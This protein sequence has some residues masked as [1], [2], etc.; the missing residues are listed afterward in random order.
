LEGTANESEIRGNFFSVRN[1][2]RS[3]EVTDKLVVSLDTFVCLLYG[4]Q[5]S[6]CVD[7]CNTSFLSQASIPTILFL[8]IV[9]AFGN[10]L[11]EQ[12]FKHSRGI[13]AY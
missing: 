3:A 11:K 9:T 12:T 4:D 7:E 5:T 10:T 8:Q 2:R 6:T 13:G 1:L